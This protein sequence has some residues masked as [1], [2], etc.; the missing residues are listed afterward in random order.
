MSKVW[1]IAGRSRGLGHAF[2]EA[3]LAGFN[4]IAGRW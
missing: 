2:T 4:V 1:F 3:V